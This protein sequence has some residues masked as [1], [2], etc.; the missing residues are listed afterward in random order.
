M[1]ELWLISVD[2]LCDWLALWMALWLTSFVTGFV[3][4]YWVSAEKQF[5]NKLVKNILAIYFEFLNLHDEG[6]TPG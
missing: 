1:V 5:S 3:T 6:P 4:A 2:W